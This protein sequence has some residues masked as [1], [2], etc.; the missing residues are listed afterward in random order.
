VKNQNVKGWSQMPDTEYFIHLYITAKK[1]W[2]KQKYMRK[3]KPG[4]P[5]Y[6]LLEKAAQ[7]VDDIGGDYAGYI[8]CQIDACKCIP[9]FPSPEHLVTDNAIKR[10]A[11]KRVAMAIPYLL[12]EARDSFYVVATGRV[13]SLDKVKRPV[14]EDSRAYSLLLKARGQKAPNDPKERAKLLE[15]VEYVLAKFHLLGRSPTDSLL[16]FKEKLNG[17]VKE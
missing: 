6:E 8:N 12:N 13:Y 1:L 4:T 9:L 11:R 14:Q 2:Y 16:R 17:T 15:D 10:Y 7:I 3:P 5:D